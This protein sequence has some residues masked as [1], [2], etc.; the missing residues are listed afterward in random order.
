MKLRGRHRLSFSYDRPVF[1]ECMTIRLRPRCD[2]SQ[3]LESFSLDATPEPAGRSDSVDLH[4]N[5]ST[6]LWF[7]ELQGRIEVVTRW[8]ATTLRTNPF[9][10]LV[11]EP[12]A[13]ELP[14][15]H[16]GSDR[17]ALSAYLRRAHGESEVDQLA[18]DTLKS[19]Q[20]ATLPF[21][22]TIAERIHDTCRSVVRTEG[23]PL[24]PRETL[25]RGEGA[26]RDLAVVFVDACRSVGLPARF[27]SG[28]KAIAADEGD[29]HLHAWA[30]VYFPGAGWR[31]YDPSLGLAV[32]DAHV[33]VAASPEPASSAPTAGSFRGTGV[34]SHLE[35]SVEVQVLS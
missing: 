7:R 21:L 18:R 30:E 12:A 28:Y 14:F 34:R 35:Y 22:T 10:F 19:V 1:V 33:L 13:L 20:S 26:C 16:P 15:E 31:G 25:S 32:A 8:E 4:G 24:P 3:H 5:D 27:A 23:D 9:D 29:R 17:A 2:A 6:L 11:S